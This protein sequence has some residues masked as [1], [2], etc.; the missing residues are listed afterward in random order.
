MYHSLLAILVKLGYESRNQDCTFALISNLTEDGSIRFD[1][2]LL[3]SIAKINP[4]SSERETLTEIREH[5]QYGTKLSMKDR[6]YEELLNTTKRIL[7]E[8]KRILEE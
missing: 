5:Y 7:G 6:T 2:T 3:N 4:E 1:S 8:S